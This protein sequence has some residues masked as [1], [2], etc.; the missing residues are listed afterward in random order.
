MTKSPEVQAREDIGITLVPPDKMG[1]VI[2]DVLRIPSEHDVTEPE[3]A[4]DRGN[5]FVLVHIFPTQNSVDVRAGD[6][7]AVAGGLANGF[8]DLGGRDRRGHGLLLL[9]CV[10][11]ARV[12]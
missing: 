7:D 12:A 11:R 3:S 2:A 1:I 4:L 5:E 8:D 6:L 9:F 10:P